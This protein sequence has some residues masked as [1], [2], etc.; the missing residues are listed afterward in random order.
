MLLQ[1]KVLRILDLRWNDMGNHG[2]KTLING[3]SKNTQITE[4]QLN[5]NKATDESIALIENILKRNRGES[6]N[7]GTRSFMRGS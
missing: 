5:G 4:L 2:V 6:D 7:T 1:N 3:L